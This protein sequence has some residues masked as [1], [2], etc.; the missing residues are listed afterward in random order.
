MLN[1][2]SSLIGTFDAVGNGIP[3]ALVGE[4][5]KLFP[6]KVAELIITESPV[7]TSIFIALSAVTNEPVVVCP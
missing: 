4:N 1:E 3:E 7:S 5:D 2:Q 6:F